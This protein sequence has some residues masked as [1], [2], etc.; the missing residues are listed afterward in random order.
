M[1]AIV[2]TTIATSAQSPCLVDT[3]PPCHWSWT[4]I[5][6]ISCAVQPQSGAPAGHLHPQ[7]WPPTGLP[8]DQKGSHEPVAWLTHGWRLTRLTD[9]LGHIHGLEPHQVGQLVD[10]DVP[11]R[12][13]LVHALDAAPLPVGP[14]DEVPQQREPENVGEL[15]LQERPPLCPVDVD[16]LQDGRRRAEPASGLNCLEQ[17]G[18]Q[19]RLHL[20]RPPNK[21]T[22]HW[23]S[24]MS[25]VFSD[26]AIQ[27]LF[28]TV[29]P[30]WGW[31]LG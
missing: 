30:T 7:L 8:V 25:D 4:N 14:V 12:L 19:Q 9:G 20:A 28:P 31:M 27:R 29:S 26:G 11:A 5:L 6:T 18:P 24:W 17:D 10:D 16:H 13:D 3:P 1:L 22:T 15:V 21:A 2:R 23:G